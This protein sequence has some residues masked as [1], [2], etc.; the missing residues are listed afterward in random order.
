MLNRNQKQNILKAYLYK[1][2]LV[3]VLLVAAFTITIIPAHATVPKLI[4]FQGKLSKTSDGT[5]VADGNYSMQFKIYDAL[6]SGNLLWT[7]T[8]DGTSST[9]QV[10]VTNGTFAVRLGSYTSLSGIN[11]NGGSLYL[12]VNFNPGTGYDGE[13]TPRKQLTSSAF[14]ILANG[15]NGDGNLIITNTSTTTS[16]S[17]ITYNPSASTNNSALLVT[18]GSLTTG[19]AF[20]V[21]QNGTGYAAIF[22]GGN[23]G[24]GTS[25]PVAT[26]FV[27]GSTGAVNPFAIASSTGTNL[28]VVGP[29][30]STTI[31]SLNQALPVRS[32]AGGSLFNGAI[33]L[34]SSDVIGNLPVANGGTGSN[35]T[36]T[37][38]NNL[39]PLNT[40]GDLLTF[41]G[42]N[43]IRFGVGSNGLCLTASSTATSGLAWSSCSSG[44]ITGSGTNGY[45]PRWSSA[46]TLAAGILLDNGIVA[47]V[48][49]SSTT[50]SFLVQGTGSNSPFQ[51]NSS[52]G[53]SLLVVGANGRIGIGSSTPNATLVVQGS[54]NLPTSDI[55]RVASSSAATILDVAS[56]GNVGIGTTSPTTFKLQVQGNIGPDSDLA[57]NLGS[58]ALRW[59]NLYLGGNLTLS[60]ETQGSILFAGPGGVVNQNNSNF[61]WDNTNNRLGVGTWPRRQLDVNGSFQVNGG[62][63]SYSTTTGVTSIDNLQLGAQTLTQ[64]ADKFPG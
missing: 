10:N 44:S 58:A 6:T 16:A 29:N 22:T 1:V 56:S 41:D 8:W 26:L 32:T 37:A 55:F 23:V 47:G 36:T 30:G 51:V 9:T 3:L 35:S 25:S 31:S 53:A 40:K 43:N 14:A 61:F 18:A 46:S 17:I 13:M 27:Q 4:N 24:V 49:A 15:V 20:N 7:E 50:V 64:T 39:S 5:N 63:I 62:A 34:A 38:F 60:T 11:F 33:N 2:L 19:P 42:T 12:T 59:N 28:F 52:T 48:N 21:T 45:I 57:Y 54:N